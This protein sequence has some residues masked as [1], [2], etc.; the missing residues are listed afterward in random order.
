MTALIESG[1]LQVVGPRTRVRPDPDGRGFLIGSAAI[2]G[3]EVVTGTLIDARVAEPDLRRSTNPLLRH[4]LAT[5]QCRPYRIPDP[6]G[7]YE[8]G[9][10]DVTARPYRV[11]DASGV[12]HPRRFAYG[13][14]TEFVHWATAAGIRPGVGSVILEDADAMARAVL[15]P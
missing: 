6:D 2:P 7:A 13:V 4:L 10:L 5:G 8:T 14:P 12:P 3:P 15:A 9:G 1:V 11:V